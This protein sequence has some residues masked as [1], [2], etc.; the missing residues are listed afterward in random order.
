MKTHLTK[1][2]VALLATLVM[3]AC[4]GGDNATSAS[5]GG[6]A[7]VVDASGYSSFNSTAL[8][9]T[10]AALPIETLS[11]AEQASL[12]FMRE[13]EKLAHDVYAQ[14]DARWGASTRVFG[15]IANSE[16]T[17]AEAVRQL[18]LRYTLVDPAATLAAGLFQNSTLQALYTQLA[19]AGAISLIEALKVG[20]AIEEI[21]MIDINTALLNID[22]QDIR[23]IYDNLLKG[24]RNHLRS[25]V[26]NLSNQGVTYVPQYMDALAYAAIISTP[27]ER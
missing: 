15:N 13:E 11:V 16:A 17:H 21:D 1:L 9:L 19:T 27:I 24:S 5:Y 10:L 20:A 14:M 8:G 3:S 22:N 25:F 26:S 18:L 6:P 7:L 2:T 23:L 4:G 12:A